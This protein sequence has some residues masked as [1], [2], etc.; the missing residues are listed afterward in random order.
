MS[1]TTSANLLQARRLGNLGFYKDAAGL[2]AAAEA[3]H[4]HPPLLLHIEISGHLI[5]Q[6]LVGAAVDKCKSRVAQMNRDQE[7]PLQ[8]ALLDLLLAS[9]EMYSTVRLANPLERAVSV[10]NEHLRDRAI[11]EYD[12]QT[13]R[14]P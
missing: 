6:G 12:K 3:E 4:P 13:V 7:E 2:Y 1:Q 9:V 10:F 5:E 11:E 14:P 8:L